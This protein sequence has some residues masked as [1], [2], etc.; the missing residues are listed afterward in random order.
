MNFWSQLGCPGEG[1]PVVIWMGFRLLGPSWRPD[2]PKSPEEAPRG[3]KTPSKTDFGAILVD[4]GFIFWLFFDW[5][6]VHFGSCCLLWC[7]FVALL[8]CWFVGLLVCRS[9]GSLLCWFS[10]LLVVCLSAV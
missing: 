10:G 9:V 2:G 3:A 5:F 6:G 8:V 7:W 1:R 4:F